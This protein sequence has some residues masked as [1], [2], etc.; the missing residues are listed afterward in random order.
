MGDPK[1]PHKTYSTPRHPWQKDRIDAEKELLTKFG[2]KNK[3]ELWKGMEMLKSFRSQARDLQARMRVSDPN[4]EKQFQALI[5]RLGRYN[6]LGHNATL[7]DVLSLSIED[8]LSRR[9]QTIVFRKNLARTPKQARQMITHG[10]VIMNG[11]RVTVPG[12][13]VEGHLEDTIIYHDTSPFTDD[14]HPIRQV[15]MNGPSEEA[16]EPGSEEGS[17]EETE[18]VA[19]AKPKVKS[20]KKGEEK[21]E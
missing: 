20:E 5:Q 16:E 14:L 6:I 11:R 18:A 12:M 2:L 9:L 8:I 21:N 1:Y 19:E 10:H 15:I 17:E 13:M 4:A 3:R 7:D